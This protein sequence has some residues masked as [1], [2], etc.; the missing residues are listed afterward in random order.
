MYVSF[1]LEGIMRKFGFGVVFC[2]VLFM[3]EVL[4][5]LVGGGKIM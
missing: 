5:F 3:F 4:I 2:C 1:L